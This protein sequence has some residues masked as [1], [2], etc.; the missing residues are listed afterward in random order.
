MYILRN[1]AA[2]TVIL[3]LFSTKY[4]LSMIA[5]HELIVT[6]LEYMVLRK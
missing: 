6:V 3:E 2:G 5:E 4:V 1:I